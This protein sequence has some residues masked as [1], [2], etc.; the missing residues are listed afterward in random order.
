V[1]AK[2]IEDAIEMAQSCPFLKLNGKLE[3]AEMVQM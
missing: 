1:Q 2:R 3:V